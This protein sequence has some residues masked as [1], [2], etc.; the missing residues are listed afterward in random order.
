MAQKNQRVEMSGLDNGKTSQPVTPA[1][2]FGQSQSES[3]EAVDTKYLLERFDDDRNFLAELTGIFGEEYPIQL[4][5][6]EAGLQTR[7]AEEVE[8]GAHSLKGALSNLAAWK[9]GRLAADLET[10]GISGD[11]TGA[12]EALRILRGELER[13]FEALSLVSQETAR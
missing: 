4:R 12:P 5:R 7:N 1:G 2:G 3:Q 10:A 6:I 9:A 11:L 8:R 13:V